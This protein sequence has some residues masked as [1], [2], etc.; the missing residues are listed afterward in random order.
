MTAGSYNNVA[1]LALTDLLTYV[2]TGS[3]HDRTKTIF[4]FD[5]F[6]HKSYAR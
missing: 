4:N 2:S 1:R 5:R 6:R 3:A